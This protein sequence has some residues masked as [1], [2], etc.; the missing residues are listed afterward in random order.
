MFNNKI[1][2]LPSSYKARTPRV[3]DYFLELSLAIPCSPPSD[4]IFFPLP[5]LGYTLYARASRVDYFRPAR[6]KI[7]NLFKATGGDADLRAPGGEKTTVKY[8]T[9]PFT[10]SPI[11]YCGLVRCG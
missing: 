9:L 8:G 7:T 1:G 3:L 2:F 11:L 6:A 5:T 10:L 4:S